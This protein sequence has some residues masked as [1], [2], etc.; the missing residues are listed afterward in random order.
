MFPWFTKNPQKSIWGTIINGVRTETICLFGM[1]VPRMNPNPEKA[2]YSKIRIIQK[3]DWLVCVSHIE[4]NRP[5]YNRSKYCWKYDSSW[6]FSKN[7]S[8]KIWAVSIHIVVWFSNENSSLSWK[9]LDYIVHS[10]ETHLKNNK[11]Y[12]PLSILNSCFCSIYSPKYQ[13]TK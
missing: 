8:P 10:T 1:P 6:Y 12:C 7:S 5:I 4:S 13:Q 2:L 3:N 11:K 9:Y